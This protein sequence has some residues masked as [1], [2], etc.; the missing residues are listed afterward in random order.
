VTVTDLCDFGGGFYFTLL[1]GL[2]GTRLRGGS[3]MLGPGNGWLIGEAIAQDN[4][5]RGTIAFHPCS[6]DSPLPSP[7][8]K[9]PL[10]AR[11]DWQPKR[12][13]GN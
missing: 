1:L 10:P 7:E 5:L 9:I 6:A 12:V 3:R 8:R 4:S 11:R 2:Q 13:F